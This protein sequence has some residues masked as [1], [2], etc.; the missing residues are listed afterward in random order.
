MKNMCHLL[1]YLLL[2]QGHHL[3][4]ALLDALLLELLARVHAAGGAGLARANLA[5][6]PFAEH[7]VHAECALGDG[8]A[9]QVFD[10]EVA[11]EVHAVGGEFVE[12]RVV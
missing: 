4:L 10:L 11:L 5:E 2:V 12:G 8:H 7:A 3:A 9:L 6:A 1:E